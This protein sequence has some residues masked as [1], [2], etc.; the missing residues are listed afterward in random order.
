MGI[1]K[2]KSVSFTGYRTSKIL[3][4]SKDPNVIEEIRQ[5]L[6]N[7]IVALY[8]QGYNTFISGMSEGFDMLAAEVV[9]RLR[10]KYPE[11]KLI[12]VVP[13]TGQELSYS[14]LDK[15]LYEII[16]NNSNEVIYTS[17]RYH[18]RAFFDRNDFMLDNSTAVLCYYD[19][20]PG[21]TMYTYNRAVENNMIINNLYEGSLKSI[22]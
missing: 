4:T 19:G 2:E 15:K 21:G 20:Q 6:K 7:K 8:E 9:L 16:F 1:N 18:D 14:N 3:K 12:S 11:M 5:N 22:N 13:F 17:E 10:T